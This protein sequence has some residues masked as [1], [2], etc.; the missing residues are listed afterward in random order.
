MHALSPVLFCL[1]PIVAFAGQSQHSARYYYQRKLH[2]TRSTCT[3]AANSTFKLVDLYQGSNF[4]ECVA[5]ILV[6]GNTN[7]TVAYSGWDFFTGGD[8]TH[9]NVRFVSRKD[10]QSQ[11]LAFVQ[12]DNVTVIAVDDKTVVPKGGNRNSSAFDA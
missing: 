11:G 8:P 1:V 2:A 9:G 5:S 4:F 3:R 6:F 10:A 7:V 12:K